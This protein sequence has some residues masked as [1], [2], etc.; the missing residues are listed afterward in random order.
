M[1][2]VMSNNDGYDFR[3][4]LGST[5]S[6]TST[7]MSNTVEKGNTSQQFVNEPYGGIHFNSDDLEIPVDH[8]RTQL[9]NASIPHHNQM[10]DTLAHDI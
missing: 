6:T 8:W 5:S 9:V 3:V 2:S 4:G 1:T 7:A 10:W